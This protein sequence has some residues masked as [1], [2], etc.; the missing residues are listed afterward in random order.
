MRYNVQLDLIHEKRDIATTAI[1][2]ILKAYYHNARDI[3]SWVLGI[4][5]QDLARFDGNQGTAVNAA[6][7]FPDGRLVAYVT[8]DLLVPGGL[9]LGKEFARPPGDITGTC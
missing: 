6:A 1:H 8:A 2:V 7:I 9:N 4:S 5:N 3:C